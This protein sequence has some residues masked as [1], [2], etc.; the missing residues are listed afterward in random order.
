MHFNYR[1]LAALRVTLTWYSLLNCAGQFLSPLKRCTLVYGWCM[2]TMRR[3]GWELPESRVTSEGTYRRRRVLLAAAAATS[4]AAAGGGLWLARRENVAIE[5]DPTSALYPV[6]RT[7]RFGSPAPITHERHATTYNNFYE[8]GHDKKIWPA[9]QKLPL[10]P[11]TIRVG[12]LVEQPFEIGID[13]LLAKMPLEERVYR[14]RCVEGW[15]MIVPWSGFALRTLVDLCRPA[16]SARFLVLRALHDPASLHG[17]NDFAHAWPYTEALAI[18]EA[19]HELAFMATGLYG[20]PLPKQNGATLRL[21]V[22][23]KYGFKSIKSVV[24]LEFTEQRPRTFW[25]TLQP[26][27][28]GFWANV[29]PA[30][31]HPRWSQATEKP[32]GSHDRIPTQLYN[33]YGEFVSGLYAHR[34]S[35]KLFF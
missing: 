18:D 23:W 28:Y 34:Q 3:R 13:E 30:V 32:L 14:H 27:E 31:D 29:N 1:T 16:G 12:G 35:E 26:D 4:I 7:D 24:A 20:K 22:P 11:W 5:P 17:Q 8:F 2:R 19:A 10:R 25:Q 21:V 9:A 15:S 6:P 33:G